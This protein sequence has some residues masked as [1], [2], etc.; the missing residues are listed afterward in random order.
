MPLIIPIFIPHQGCP[1]QCLFCNQISISGRHS[2]TDDAGL[3]RK[4]IREWLERNRKHQE[5]QV[6]FYGGSFTCLPES[7]QYIFLAAVQPFIQSGEVV[8]IRLSTRP[9]CIDGKACD[10]LKEYG[11]QTVELGVQSLDDQVLKAALRG[12]TREDSIRAAGILKENGMH[13][14]IQLMPGLPGETSRSWLKTVKQVVQLKPECVRLYPTLV[15][16]GSGLAEQYRKGNFLPISMNRAIAYCCKAKEIFDKAGIRIL[17]MGLQPSASLEKALLAGPYH[18][19]FG[20]LVAARD[21]FRQAR[22]HLAMCPPEATITM[23]IADRDISA[24]VGP[25]RINMRR[26][27]DL[28]K[29]E[30]KKLILERDTTISRGTLTYV[31]AKPS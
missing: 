6:A 31:I 27:Q 26:L 10:F 23:K 20:E 25:R 3:V 1:Q 12:H 7:R 15:I 30:N 19:S 29:R 11:V 14:G 21:W 8:S 4:T 16:A 13:L 2:P 22:R 5:V 9:D 18:P 17:R 24:F 28:E